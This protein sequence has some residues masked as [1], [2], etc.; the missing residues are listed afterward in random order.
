VKKTSYTKQG[1]RSPYET[2]ITQD[3]TQ[4]TQSQGSASKIELGTAQIRPKIK[5]QNH[6]ESK[7]KKPPPPTP[8]KKNQ[9]PGKASGNKTANHSRV[10]S[11]H[12]K[13]KEKSSKKRP[14]MQNVPRTPANNPDIKKP[15]AKE[16]KRK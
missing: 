7:K 6:T 2:R 4:K 12:Q 3:K 13:K 8:K 16:K 14:P 15:S 10:G 11:K 1:A 9:V 5:Q